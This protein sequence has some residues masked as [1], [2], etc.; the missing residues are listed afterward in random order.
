[1]SVSGKKILVVGDFMWPWYQEACSA[2]L[3]SNGN[4]VER[5]GWFD[6][7]RYWTI[8]KSEPRFHSFI[9]RIQYRLSFGPIIWSLKKKLLI[10]ALKFQ[11]D[12]VWFYNV[13]IISPKFVKK[14][15]SSL[16][17]SI[18]VQYSNDNPFSNN[19]STGIW[20]NYLNSIPEFDVHF[21]YRIQNNRDYQRVGSKNTFLLR[22]YFIPEEDFPVPKDLIP[23]KFKCDIVFAGHF[24]NDER[25]QLL[26]SICLSG[27]KLNLFGGG[28]D[29]S[30]LKPDSPLL[31]LFPVMPVTNDE[32]RFAICG[33][34]VA[35]CILSTLNRDTYTR[36]CFQ[37]PAMKQV[38]LSQ[39]TD[40]LANMFIPGKEAVFFNNSEELIVKLRQLVSD[41]DLR[42]QI[43]NNGYKKVYDSGHDVK[44]RMSIFL[45]NIY[46]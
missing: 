4:I 16:P 43:A 22:S 9:H 44:T 37:I 40:D 35:L 33:A 23:E 34:K 15:K 10:Q 36:R 19:A 6:E 29:K 32:Y 38:M 3:E 2:A 30:K 7:F 17:S 5:F 21:A 12:I 13:K 31:D 24:E 8:G 14:L 28:W 39:F 42:M 1:V 27:F 41:D 45:E 25:I 20:K 26:E 11:P 18:F 46:S